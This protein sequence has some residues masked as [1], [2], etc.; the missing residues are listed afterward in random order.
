M[1]EFKEIIVEIPSIDS[2]IEDDTS[3][4]G[5]F[6]CGAGCSNGMAC[7]IGCGHGVGG[8]CGTGCST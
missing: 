3:I 7:G 2:V 8:A 1:I 6:I 5:G 4:A